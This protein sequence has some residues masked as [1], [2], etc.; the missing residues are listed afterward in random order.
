MKF[1]TKLDSYKLYC[2]KN[3]HI[4]LISPFKLFVHFSFF[5]MK[6]SATDFSAPIGARVFQFCVHLQVGKVYCVA[7]K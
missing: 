4:M 7:E 2:V 1:G 3:S 5:T 6:I